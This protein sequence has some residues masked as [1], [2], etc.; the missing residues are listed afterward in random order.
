VLDDIRS[1]INAVVDGV[2]NMNDLLP[3]LVG[4]VGNIFTRL[5]NVER[6]VQYGIEDIRREQFSF[7]YSE[8]VNSHTYHIETE[9]P[10]A[11]KSDD[12]VYLR[13]TRNDNTR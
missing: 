9:N 8:H 4:E 1:K 2:V 13:G 12:H 11:V 6:E 7:L 3:T 10:I 5:G